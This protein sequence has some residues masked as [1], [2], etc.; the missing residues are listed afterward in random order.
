MSGG[1]ASS[2][3]ASLAFE[4]LTSSSSH[5]RGTGVPRL[6]TGVEAHCHTTSSAEL[7]DKPISLV[8]EAAILNHSVEEPLI[9]NSARCC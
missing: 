7:T 8:Q 6:V 5:S 4:L 1:S 3:N 9:V 2:S